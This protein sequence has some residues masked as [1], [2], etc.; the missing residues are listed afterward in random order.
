MTNHLSKISSLVAVFG[1]TALL[2]GCGGDSSNPVGSNPTPT[3]APTAGTV[4]VSYTFTGN[5]APSKVRLLVIDG[6][7]SGETC[8]TVAFNPTNG[9]VAQR[10][11]LPINGTANFTN[12]S[13]GSR[14][15]VVAIGEKAN[16]TRVAQACH[17]Q[18]NV[19]GG[20]TTQ[21]DLSLENWVASMTGVYYVDQVANIGLPQD[22][23]SALLLLQASCGY[24]GDPQ[25]CSMVS[26]VVDI[27]T[28][29]DVVSEWT[30]DQNPDGTFKGTVR[31]VEVA[32][33]D[34]GT[35]DL[36]LGDFT[37][38]VPGSTVMEYSNF[39]STIQFGNLVL[40]IIE[41]VL[42]Y[43]LGALGPAGSA[44]ITTLAGNYVSPM[45]FTG[46]GVLTD[47]DFDGVNEK[48]SG[49]LTGHIEIAS[50]QHDFAMSYVATRQ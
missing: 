15:L 12:V 43:D 39:T 10:G 38:T 34:V 44:L 33:V 36:V 8:T 5:E 21:V 19:L 22:I 30:I 27:L 17:D 9:V 29:L 24:L 37:G 20:E 7:V 13:M 28:S 49:N 16:G 35:I 41:D 47:G 2:A 48:I 6:D 45:S 23:Q 3:P 18:V 46:N 42:G 1:A 4:N 31:W 40:F 25:L 26:Q 14:Y 50:W 11:N 32:G